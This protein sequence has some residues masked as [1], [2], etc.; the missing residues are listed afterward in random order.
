LSK[1][2][3]FLTFS[4]ISC[5]WMVGFLTTP[6]PHESFRMVQQPNLSGLQTKSDNHYTLSLINSLLSRLRILWWKTKD[7]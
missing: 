6:I 5:S 2:A 3:V 7:L 4:C 1:P